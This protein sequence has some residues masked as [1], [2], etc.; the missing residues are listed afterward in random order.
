[1]TRS[2]DVD[3]YILMFRLHF[4]TLHT[5]IMLALFSY[6]KI[7]SKLKTFWNSFVVNNVEHLDKDKLASN[8]LKCERLRRLSR[9][10]S[11]DFE[12]EPIAAK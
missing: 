7:T 8:D 10:G 3:K 1:M 12:T 4:S 2:V 9:I 11:P 6:L 5:Y